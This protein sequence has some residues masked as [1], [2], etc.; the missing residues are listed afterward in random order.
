[1]STLLRS[2]TWLF[3]LSASAWAQD[4]ADLFQIKCATC[5]SPGSAA[6]AP[7]PATLRQMTAAHILEALESGKMRAIGASLT[8]AQ[9]EALAKSLG[10]AEASATGSEAGHCSS[11]QA[12]ETGPGQWNGW[13]VDAANTRYQDAKNAGLD[14]ASV[15][16]LK[17]K[18]AFGFP[19]ATTAFGQPTVNGGRLF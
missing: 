9:R 16:K 2:S 6:G 10:L 4:T 15:R 13:G 1:M 12:V 11:S 18:W 8:A 17:L 7:L 19:G 14:R 3:L 5:H